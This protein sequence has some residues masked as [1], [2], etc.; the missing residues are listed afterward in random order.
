MQAFREVYQIWRNRKDGKDTS[1][2]KIAII[3][4]EATSHF[5]ESSKEQVDELATILQSLTNEGRKNNIRCFLLSQN[6]RSDFIGSRS[7]RSSITH[8][9]FHRTAEAEIKLFVESM[10]AKERRM[11]SSLPAGHIF[12]YPFMYQLRVPYIS[13]DDIVD[14]ADRYRSRSPT[15]DHAHRH[16]ESRKITPI[17]VSPEMPQSKLITAI[18][19]VLKCKKQGMNKEDTIYHVFQI[20]KGGKSERWNIASRFYDNVIKKAT[21]E[22]A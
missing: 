17:T 5:I 20:R 19:E 10:P 9:I 14:F 15:R 8:V 12:V 6:W 7:V 22:N 11:I 21:D 13:Q 4:D 18:K 1:K 3:L 2:H 16:A